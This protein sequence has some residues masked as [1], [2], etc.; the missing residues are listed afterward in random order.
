MKRKKRK[1]FEKAKHDH[2]QKYTIIITPNTYGRTHKLSLSFF[3]AKNA[4]FLT[5]LFLITVILL[6]ISYLGLLTNYNKS[7]QDLLTL[8]SINKEQQMQLYDMN[9]L[10]KEVDQKLQYLDLLETKSLL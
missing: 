9:E 7:K 5:G 10:A 1:Q 4:L 8:Q 3:W 6:V 2:K